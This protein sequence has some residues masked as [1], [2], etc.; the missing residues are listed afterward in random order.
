MTDLNETVVLFWGL[1]MTWEWVTVL[2][3]DNIIYT[4]AQ[5]LVTYVYLPD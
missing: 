4:V 2:R 3:V 5:T 1:D